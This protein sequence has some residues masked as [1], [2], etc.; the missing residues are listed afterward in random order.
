[1]TTPGGDVYS[2]FLSNHLNY[3]SWVLTSILKT[4]NAAIHLMGFNSYIGPSNT[5][6]VGSTPMLYMAVGCAGLGIFGFWLAFILSQKNTLQ[7]KILWSVGG[8]LCIWLINCIRVTLLFVALNNK[9]QVDHFI[10]HHDFFNFCCY[11]VIIGMMFL[12]GSTGKKEPT[13]S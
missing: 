1:L 4:S 2:P 10:D 9:W 3:V 12:Y 7:A 11:A 8:I 6:Y 5:L 13:Q